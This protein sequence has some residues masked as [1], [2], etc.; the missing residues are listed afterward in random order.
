MNV[1]VS[2]LKLLFQ[3]TYV[4]DVDIFTHTFLRKKKTK[5]F[6]L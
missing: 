4:L 3:L 1:L 5:T 6:F 2:V